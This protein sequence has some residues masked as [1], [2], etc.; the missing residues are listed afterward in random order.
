MK[1]RIVRFSKCG[2][3]EVLE[4]FDEKISSP[5]EGEVRIKVKALGL[6]QAEVMLREGRYVG[7]SK[8]PSRI[9]IEASVC[10][11]WGKW[12]REKDSFIGMSSFGVSGPAEELYDYFKI[13]KVELVE[14][15][16]NMLK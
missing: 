7:N 16:R 9:G 10:F 11:G 15:S 4:I 14:K 8:F 1:N 2:G 5:A 13:N 6:N 3:P 12:L